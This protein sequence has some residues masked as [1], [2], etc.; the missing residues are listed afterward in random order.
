MDFNRLSL[1][2]LIMV[3]PF[4]LVSCGGTNV[5]EPGARVPGEGPYSVHVS[6]YVGTTTMGSERWSRAEAKAAATRAAECKE[7]QV[8][9]KRIETGKV[10]KRNYDATAIYNCVEE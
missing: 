2:G 10:D 5:P 9:L 1:L 8:E 4:G 6:P 7:G 3:M